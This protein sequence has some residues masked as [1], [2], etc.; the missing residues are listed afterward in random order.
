MNY[1]NQTLDGLIN[2]DADIVSTSELYINDVLFVS[3]TGPTGPTGIQGIPGSSNSVFPYRAET[4]STSPPI[5]SA[6]I[7]WNNSVQTWSTII[8]I[9][10]LNQNNVDIDPILNAI[11]INDSVIIQTKL[12][13]VKIK[14]GI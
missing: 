14:N 12:I 6:S 4:V 2:I 1:F 13:L 5:S 8:Y 7:E 11:E 3:M 10:H 9:S